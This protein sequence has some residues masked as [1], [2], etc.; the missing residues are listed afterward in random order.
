MVYMN[1]LAPK[2]T[3][4]NAQNVS[5]VIG[6][7]VALSRQGDLFAVS[8]TRAWKAIDASH[9]D[10]TVPLRVLG[11]RLVLGR[12]FRLARPPECHSGVGHAQSVRWRDADADAVVVAGVRPVPDARVV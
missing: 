9:A 8:F 11:A 5:D 4:P 3:R 7:P 10:L 1:G 12:H 2:N 6:N